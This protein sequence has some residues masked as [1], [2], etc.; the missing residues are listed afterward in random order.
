MIAVVMAVCNRIQNVRMAIHSWSLQTN[1][2]FTLIVADDGST[3]PIEQLVQTYAPRMSIAYCRQ[4]GPQGV[5]V[6]LNH[7]SRFVTD[8]YIWYTD[9][10][11]IFNPGAVESACSHIQTHP[12]R[13]IAG[14][15]D[16]MREQVITEIDIEHDFGKLAASVFSL[17]H[18]KPLWFKHKLAEKCN[19]ILGANFIIPRQ[20]YWDVGGWDE[21]IPGSNA[22]DCDFGW[23]LS[24]EGYKLLTCDCIMGYHQWHPSD[25]DTK[26]LGAARALPYIFRKHGQPVPVQWQPYDEG[27]P[28]G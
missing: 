24:D 15:Y 1:Q 26:K 4:E 28:L 10:D 25:G 5:A 27:G 14:R 3:D 9:G 18:R 21:N 20:A 19:A 11:I 22:N 13:V 16:W 8:D 23:C 2:D 12:D 17:D 7:A 6:N